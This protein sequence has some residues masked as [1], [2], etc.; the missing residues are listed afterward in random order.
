[1]KTTENDDFREA[2]VARKAQWIWALQGRALGFGHF[3]LPKLADKNFLKIFHFALD[4][5]KCSL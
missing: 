1:V 3:P 4:S 5:R 2:G